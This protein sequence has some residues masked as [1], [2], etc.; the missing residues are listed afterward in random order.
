ANPINNSD[1]SGH[2]LLGEASIY[3]SIARIAVVVA[4]M[5]VDLGLGVIRLVAL[6]AVASITSCLLYPNVCRGLLNAAQLTIQA[7]QQLLQLLNSLSLGS[8]GGGGGTGAGS[9]GGGGG[10]GTSGGGGGIPNTWPQ[11]QSGVTYNSNARPGMVIQLQQGLTTYATLPLFGLSPDGSD[12]TVRQDLSALI[13]LRHDPAVPNDAATKR[14]ADAALAA[15]IRYV[16]GIF[17]GGIRIGYSQSFYFN[18]PSGPRWRLDV[19][20]NFGWN[21][22]TY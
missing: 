14:N 13:I 16:K 3:G 6:L 1:P 22:H 5:G 19:Q 18:G 7:Y 11:S 4:Q 10:G 12:V 17:P 9:G 2:D 15:A 8:A 21:L 20:N